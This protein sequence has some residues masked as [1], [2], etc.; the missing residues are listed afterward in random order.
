MTQMI[1]VNLPVADVAA[2]TAFYE[3]I[4]FT[5]D[6]RFSNEEAS[7]MRWSETISFMLL[8]H[9]FYA[10]FTDKRI[11]DPRTTSQALLCLSADS[12]EAVDTML[13]LA[14]AAGGRVHPPSPQEVSDVMYGRSFED[15][16]GH[17]LE[18]MWMDVAG[19]EAA[20]AAQHEAA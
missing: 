5:K 13:A 20:N 1:F 15:L 18:L 16:D 8:S 4:G 7:A 19:F 3:A 2:S 11:G 17:G 6:P 10:T 9:R 12:R 14:T